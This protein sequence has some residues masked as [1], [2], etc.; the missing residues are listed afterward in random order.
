MRK[1]SLFFLFLFFIK[2][3]KKRLE[4]PHDHWPPVLDNSTVGYPG[5]ICITVEFLALCG[6]LSA[7]H[8]CS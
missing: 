1:V 2:I 4:Q 6:H 8:I 5:K 7:L 3:Q